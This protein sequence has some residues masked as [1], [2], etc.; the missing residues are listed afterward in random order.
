MSK[1]ITQLDELIVEVL[2]EKNLLQEDTSDKKD[3]N[4]TQKTTNEKIED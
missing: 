2:R 4:R 1:K 3:N